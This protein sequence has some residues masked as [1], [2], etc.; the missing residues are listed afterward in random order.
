MD[1]LTC[2][3]VAGTKLRPVL[4]ELA[5]NLESFNP[6][7]AATVLKARRPP[8]P[9]PLTARQRAVPPLQPQPIIRPL[10]FKW[11]HDCPLGEQ[12]VLYHQ[13]LSAGRAP[14]VQAAARK[15]M[16]VAR[17]RVPPQAVAAFSEHN[18]SCRPKRTSGRLCSCSSHAAD[19]PDGCRCADAAVQV[20]MS[21]GHSDYVRRDTALAALIQPLAGEYGMHNDAPQGAPTP[22]ASPAAP[23]EGVAP[24][25]SGEPRRSAAAQ[26]ARKQPLR[27]R[28]PL[29]ESH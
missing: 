27:R 15:H 8:T 5:F 11:C 10:V 4:N 19:A 1:A 21:I 20:Q 7:F 25:G 2:F 26:R 16:H 12:S 24:S 28:H 6:A 18:R 23:R 13:A 17:C 3:A 14:A 22:G 9:H 29:S